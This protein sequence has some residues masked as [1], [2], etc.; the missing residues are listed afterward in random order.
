MST[1]SGQELVI[2]AK[3]GIIV[4]VQRSK[5]QKQKVVCLSVTHVK[6]EMM[7]LIWLKL[8]IEQLRMRKQTCIS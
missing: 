1:P 3:T 8:M 2:F 6:F 7:V 4:Y 5:L